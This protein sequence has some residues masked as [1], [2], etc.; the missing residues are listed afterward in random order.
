MQLGLHPSGNIH[1]GGGP[2]LFHGGILVSMVFSADTLYLYIEH[3]EIFLLHLFLGVAFFI[4]FACPFLTG[5]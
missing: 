4:P 1:N 2:G 3:V 5:S